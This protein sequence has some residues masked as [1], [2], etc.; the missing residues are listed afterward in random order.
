M[1][2]ATKLEYLN[3]TKSLLKDSI[4]SLGGEITSQTTF[5]QY[6]TE[7]DSIYSKLPKVS[8]TGSSISLSPTLKGRLGSVLK[9]NTLQDGTPSPSSP[10]EIQSVTGLQKVNVCGKNLFD[11]S[12]AIT[13][14]Y[15]SSTGILTDFTNSFC[16]LINVN[17]NTKYS[18][19]IDNNYSSNVRLN[20][21]VFDDTNQRLAQIRWGDALASESSYTNQNYTMP[22][23]AK[24]ITISVLDMQPT[25]ENINLVPIQL[26]VGSTATTYEE[27]QSQEYEINLGKNLFDGDFE[28]GGYD[29]GNGQKTASNDRIRCINYIKVEPNTPYTF[30]FEND[31][32][33]YF[34]EYDNSKT[35]LNKYTLIMYHTK[36]GTITT[37][38]NTKYITFYYIPYNHTLITD[39]QCQLEKGS[40]ATSYSPYFTPIYLR[41]SKDG[42]YEDY[43][44]G[45]PNNWSIKRQIRSITLNG[46][47]TYSTNSSWNYTNTSGFIYNLNNT[48]T[49]I[50]SNR[51]TYSANAYGSDTNGIMGIVWSNQLLFRVS[52]TIASSVADFKTWLSNN[53]VEI[54]YPL[55]TETTETITNTELISQLNALYYANSYNGTTNITITSED[56]ELIMTAS[57]LKGDTQ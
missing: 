27:Y 30:S 43:I 29:T 56:L 11:K 20:I 3:E 13:G 40:Q 2:T 26:E 38:S 57:A 47:E 50:L 54:S 9:G 35:Y 33:A 53:N 32:S 8:G 5:R 41:K 25:T 19:K 10:V 37:S 31:G 44:T 6:A 1:S 49:N 39:E 45:S 52:N 42:T 28:T 55:A 18:L 34:L 48:N 21:F 7:L 17:E 16:E 15:Y 36:L 23:G 51:F 22:S 12:S 46:Q 14:K 24:Y 4:N